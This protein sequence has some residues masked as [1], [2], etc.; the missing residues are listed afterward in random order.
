MF[1]SDPV[2]EVYG[3]MMYIHVHIIKCVTIWR[4]LGPELLFMRYSAD[5]QCKACSKLTEIRAIKVELGESDC[6]VGP[7]VTRDG[8][9]VTEAAVVSFICGTVAWR[10]V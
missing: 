1:Y 7:F 2:S 3:Q 10:L 9:S 8:G 4:I 6:E 5:E